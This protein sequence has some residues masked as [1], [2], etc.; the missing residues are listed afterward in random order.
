MKR[1]L[2]LSL[3]GAALSCSA[4]A[5]F[6]T[7]TFAWFT[8][9]STVSFKHTTITAGSN[10]KN[11]SVSLIPLGVTPAPIDASANENIYEANAAISD[12]SSAFGAEFYAK[13]ASGS[14]YEKLLQ[15]K[16]PGYV[17]RIGIKVTTMA[18]TQPAK[19]YCTAMWDS[20]NGTANKVLESN[21][22]CGFIECANDNFNATIAED[23]V[24]YAFV[25]SNPSDNNK[26]INADGEQTI[27]SSKI[28]QAA[29]NKEVFEYSGVETHY[30]LFS[31]WMEGTINADQDG[32]RGGVVNVTS[33]FTSY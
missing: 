21:L 6:G 22:R 2:K 28:A 25:K 4:L 3:F 5:A 23:T 18:L 10:N 8:T 17:Y 27:D 30:Y 26:Y 1:K 12:V 14:G 15:N 29:S 16:Y 13:K 20:P 24:C 11:I 19:V 31:V 9:R 32:A 7:A 33:L